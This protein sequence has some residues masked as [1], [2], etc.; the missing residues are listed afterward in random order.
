MDK[1][2]TASQMKLT[3][4]VRS[5]VLLAEDDEDDYMLTK[6][7]FV[8]TGM[9]HVLY[10]VKDGEELMDYLLHQGA[11]SDPNYAPVP[12]LI[13]LDLNMPKKNGYE[14]LKEIKSN[15]G[16]RQIPIV[17][18]TTSKQKEDV[19]AAYDLGANSF[20]TKPGDFSH[21]VNMIK[22]VTQYWFEESKLP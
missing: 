6:E 3:N 1:V 19:Q 5:T 14:A 12:A 18:L 21:F 4:H 10:R 17:V 8:E 9:A 2:K 15:P 16:L 11:Y 13:L 20:I 7:A 22:S